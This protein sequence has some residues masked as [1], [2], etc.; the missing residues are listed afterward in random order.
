MDYGEMLEWHHRH[1]A[2]ITIA[3]IRVAPEEANRF[4]VMDI[5]PDYRIGGFDEK[6]Q[7]GKPVRSRFDPSRVSASMGIYVF[8]T[9]VLLRALHEDA[10][11]PGSS[12]DFGKDV[13]PNSLDKYR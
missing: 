10:Q 4:G 1:K 9:D 12:H 13:L 5:G 11:D 2:D 7:H 6:P 8:N 3:A